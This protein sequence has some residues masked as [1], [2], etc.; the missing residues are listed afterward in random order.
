MSA[1]LPQQRTYGWRSWRDVARGTILGAAV[2]L[3]I[4]FL[5]SGGTKHMPDFPSIWRNMILGV[6]IMLAARLLETMLSWAI[7]QSRYPVFFRVVLYAAGGWIGFFGGVLIVQAIRGKHDDDFGATPYHLIYS[8]SAAAVIS[9]IIGFILHHNRKRNDRLRAS[10]ERLKE[11]EFAEKELEIAREMQQRLLPPPIV[12][13]EGFRVTARTDAAHIVGG[14]F[15]DVVRLADDAEAI[16]AADVSGKGIAASLIMAS[17]KAMIPFLAST[18]GAADVMNALNRSLCEQL[19]RRE[20]VAMLFVRFTPANGEMEIVNA[21]MPDPLVLNT[22]A[23]PRT[24]AFQGDRL[25]LGAMRTS[26]YES[27]RITLDRGERLV[28]FSDGLPEALVNDA[29]I[30]Y[31]RVESIVRSMT[32]I[33]GVVDELRAMG[34]RIDDDLTI[35]VIERS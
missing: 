29:P 12:E 31:D 5:E 1:T 18:G 24:V 3:C 25:P 30:G 19:Q 21:G 2:G 10:I 4:P 7:E 33:D 16:V 15:Y 13:R 6:T 28:I 32:S 9:T 27:T 35:V 20:F 26:R 34:A 11:H 23:A 14:D 8:V 17:C 22:D